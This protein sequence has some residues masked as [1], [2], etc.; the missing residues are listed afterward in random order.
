MNSIK[1]PVTHNDNMIP[2]LRELCKMRNNGGHGA[3]GLRLGPESR[4][5]RCYVPANVGGL[6]KHDM[7]CQRQRWRERV[8]D[9][10]SVV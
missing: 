3:K 7:I 4:G 1:P 2:A 9:R 8:L 6:I 5:H 10:K